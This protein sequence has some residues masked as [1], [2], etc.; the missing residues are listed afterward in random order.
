MIITTEK[1]NSG[2]VKIYGDGE[3]LFS[4][5]AII[6]FASDLSE[7]SEINEEELL[8]LKAE[9]DSSFAYESAL[10][11]LTMR[12][13]SKKEL[14]GKLR[15]KYGAAAAAD[16]VDKCEELGLIDDEKFARYYASELYERK[17]FSA[18][19][20]LAELNMKGID[21]E[22]AE[23]TVN[24]LDIDSDRAIICIIN[25]MRLDFPLSDRDRNRAVRRLV[26]MGYSFSEIKKQLDTAGYE[27]SI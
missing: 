10:R 20:I 14:Y 27:S 12:S 8:S 23:N 24:T 3:Y 21:R 4:V 16:A 19:R 17:H 25:K 5:P 15:M 9:G 6:W 18:P 11:M 13:H 1:L 7:D 2:K 26:S 22:I